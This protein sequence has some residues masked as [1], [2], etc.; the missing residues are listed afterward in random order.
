MNLSPSQGGKK[1]SQ[2]VSF[3]NIN[4]LILKYTLKAN[5]QEKPK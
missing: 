5:E 3:V 4:E 2:T 1:K